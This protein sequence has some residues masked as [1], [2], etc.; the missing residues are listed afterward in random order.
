MP[1]RSRSET[2]PPGVEI[3]LENQRRRHLIAELASPLPAE[4][5][6]E[7]RALRGRGGQPLVPEVDRNRYGPAEGL[8]ERFGPLRR[9]TGCPIHVAGPPDDD[10]GGFVLPAELRDA[11]DVLAEGPVGKRGER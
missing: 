9:R 4:I 3:R 6:C 10:P 1:L 5:R 2:A 11:V 7:K 8:S